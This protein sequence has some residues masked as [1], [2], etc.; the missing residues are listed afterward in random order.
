MKCTIYDITLENLKIIN[1]ET[2]QKFLSDIE[3]L[4]D[5]D[6]RFISSNTRLSYFAIRDEIIV[7][8][9]DFI[10]SII[11]KNIFLL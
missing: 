3:N 9:M 5:R 1:V 11:T 8:K 2:L 10:K 4:N 6:I 7:L